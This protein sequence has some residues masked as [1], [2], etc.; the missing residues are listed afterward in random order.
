MRY[1]RPAR[2]TDCRCDMG[3]F[4]FGLILGM[5]MGITLMCIIIVSREEK[6]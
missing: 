1:A 4:I 3:K 2:R 5:Y 6:R